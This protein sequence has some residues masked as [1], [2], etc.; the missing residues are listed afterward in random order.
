MVTNPIGRF[1]KHDFSRAYTTLRLFSSGPLSGQPTDIEWEAKVARF[2]LDGDLSPLFPYINAVAERAQFYAKP[3]YIK[4]MFADRL[5][6]FYP[7]RGAFTPIRDMAEAMDFLPELLGF[8]ADVARRAPDIVPDHKKYKT[9]SAV[10]IY[11]LLPGNNCRVCGYATCMAFAAALSR[12]H[13]ETTLCP[14]LTRPVEETATFPVYDEQ[15]NLVRTVSMD[16]DTTGLRREIDRQE[17]RIRELQSRLASFES[18]HAEDFSA[19]NA[20][21]PAP[22]T[23]REIQVLAQ[24]VEGATNREISALLNISAHTVKSHVTGIFNKLGVNDRAQAAAWGAVHG[25]NRSS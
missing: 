5:C 7:D 9:A 6:A 22:L 24:I 21:L 2:E 25:L 4:F 16:I 23:D 3:V 8:L 15:G 19:A 10:D 14:H 12:R 18:A 13:T 1:E 17:E 11:R 20:A